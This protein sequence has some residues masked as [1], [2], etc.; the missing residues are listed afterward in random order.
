VAD[1]LYLDDL[2]V[3]QQFVSQSQTVDE[4]QIVRFAREFDP[5]PFH[6]DEAAAKRTVF[7]GLVASGWQ[8]AA[9]SMRLVVEGGAPIAGGMVGA[10][11]EITW[12]KPVRPGDTLRVY[13]E[14][15]EIVPSRSRPD[16]G[17]V[18]IRNETRN[19]HGD[20]VQLFVGK[21]VVPRRPEG[22]VAAHRVL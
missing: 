14:V 13:C 9:L 10:G 4:G 12:P 17:I 18:T 21:L 7:G 20:V 3:G 16:R 19:Q 5:Q 1:F 6:V 8:T 2:R 11:G 22:T 15:V